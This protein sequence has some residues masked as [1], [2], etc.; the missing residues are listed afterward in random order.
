M[1]E[2]TRRVADLS[3]TKRALLE[4]RLK[5][6]SAIGARVEER[7]ANLSPVKQALLGLRLK[8]KQRTASAPSARSVVERLAGLS[9]VKR[10]L[11]KLRL[12]QPEQS[13][14]NLTQRVVNLSEAKRRL[15]ELRLHPPDDVE[16]RQPDLAQRIAN[17]S[18]AKR[19][20]LQLRLGPENGE[21]TQPASASLAQRVASLSPAKQA[22]FELWLH[23]QLEAEEAVP[24]LPVVEPE[25]EAADSLPE[26][27]APAA[28]DET[29]AEADGLEWL[30]DT[31][32]EEVEL[33]EWLLDSVAEDEQPP[34]TTPEA[35]VETPARPEGSKRT[36]S[37][38]FDEEPAPP[39]WLAEDDTPV[40]QPATPQPTAESIPAVSPGKKISGWLDTFKT[41]E[42]P[43]PEEARQ[44]SEATG[45]LAGLSGL[46]PAEKVETTKPDHKDDDLLAAAQE[47]YKIATQAPQPATLPAPLS[48]QK[49]LVGSAI[50]A[51]LYLV[52]VAL[53]ALPLFPA[54]QKVSSEAPGRR[55]PWTEPTGASGDTLDSQ[56]RQL[57]SEQ[58]GIIDL[59][60]PGA[61]AL[62][63]FDY[64]TA[65]QG[66]MQPLAEAVIGRLKGQG[67]RIIA[68]SLE[69]E[70]AYI[71]QQTLDKL[72]QERDEPY[73]VEAINLGYLPGQVA[74]VRKLVAD[75]SPFAQI[76]D[77]KDGVKFNAQNQSNWANVQTLAQIDI[78]AVL[79]DNPA[80][81]RWWIEQLEMAPQPSDRPQFLLAATSANAAPFLQPYRQS[82]QLDGLI[83]GVNGAAAVEAGRNNF[84]PARQMLDSQGI[85]HLI[86]V[87][88]IAIGTIVG[89]M[90][91]PE[92]PDSAEAPPQNGA[93]SAA[94]R[95]KQ[96]AERD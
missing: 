69:P 15:L 45:M 93:G 87:I 65:T 49:Q 29:E 47:F 71:A 13:T 83:F 88:L 22:L 19:R 75:K 67:M 9:P 64:S 8:E 7:V 34:T 73:G 5:K 30:A 27:S 95:D 20:L 32:F 6:Q 21:S 16:D 84:G 36:A 2:I 57:I 38:V 91:R 77:F 39:D 59:Q 62:V 94:I 42:Q 26:S 37:P 61:V 82:N 33:P 28:P 23:K 80:T 72:L 51:V 43:E 35:V 81:A 52:F 12:A 11:L 63:S 50:K 90:P 41:T 54:L 58:L 40:S 3:P 53:I 60:Q 17:L 4:Q 46:L 78:I 18:P 89:W 14:D 74:A 31:P 44:T 48:R 25:P 68:V 10:A 1:D 85:A 55:L 92:P 56:R 24:S 86:I 79:A 96:P 70:G 66:E 76:A